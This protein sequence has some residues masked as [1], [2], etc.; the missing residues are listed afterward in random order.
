MRL[1][2]LL[3]A[4]GTLVAA[5]GGDP[6]VSRDRWAWPVA[7]PRSIVRPFIAPATAYSAGHRGI[8][9]ETASTTIT[10]PADGVVHF[11]GVVVDRPVLSIRHGDGIISSFEPVETPL[12]AGA[13]VH[14]G[15]P[16][17]TLLPG[18]CSRLCLHFGVRERGEYVSPLLYLGGLERSV[19][20]PTRSSGAGAVGSGARVGHGVALLEPLGRDVGIDLGRAEAGVAQHLLHGP[21]IRAPVEQVRRGGVP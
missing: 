20:L 12:A 9:V 16:L 11:A 7:A 18:H 4:V 10:A 19:L 15:E 8:D 21:Q 2:V 1:A 14:R 6:V 3:L 17:G 5:G 13:I